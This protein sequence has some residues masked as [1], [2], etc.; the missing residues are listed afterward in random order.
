VFISGEK[1]NA[2]SFEHEVVSHPEVKST[3]VIGPQRFKA[4]LLVELV[5]PKPR[6]EEERKD[7]LNRI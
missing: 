3:L 6:D 4:P 1:T 2:I 5:N 7:F